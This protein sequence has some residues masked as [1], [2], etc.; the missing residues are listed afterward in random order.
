LKDSWESKNEEQRKDSLY[1]VPRLAVERGR[2]IKSKTEK[3]LLYPIQKF[4]EIGDK[5]RRRNNE[6]VHFILF[7][8]WLVREVGE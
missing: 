8:D 4:A 6:R 1:L 2:R 7:P 5:V 3:W